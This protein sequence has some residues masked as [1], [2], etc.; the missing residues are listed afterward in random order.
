[1]PEKIKPSEFAAKIKQK[2]PSYRS[3][4]DSSLVAKIVEKYPYYKETI[5]F[6]ATEKPAAAPVAP[7][8]EVPAIDTEAAKRAQQV[9]S[10]KAYSAA[11]GVPVSDV[12]AARDAVRVTDLAM[13]AQI[14]KDVAEAPERKIIKEG[15][16]RA[17]KQTALENAVKKELQSNNIAP[18][19]GDLYWKISEDKIRKAVDEGSL[20]LTTNNAGEPVYKRNYGIIES[21]TK[22]LE[23]SE[24]ART[25]SEVFAKDDINGKIRF[26][27]EYL[28]REP[29]GVAKFFPEMMAGAVRPITE[30]VVGGMAGTAIAPGAGTAAGILGS[31]ITMT[32]TAYNRGAMD[33][34]IQMYAKDIEEIK[35]KK[36]AVTEKDKQEAM[37]RA[38]TQGVYGGLAGVAEAA[39]LTIP[40]G[41]PAA[42]KGLT[43]ALK[44]FG[45][46]SAQ[47]AKKMAAI[48]M[49]TASVKDFAASASGYNVSTSESINNILESGVEGAKT[50]VAF[51]IFHAPK[52]FSK[53]VVAYAK[54]Y[55]STIPRPELNNMSSALEG[56]GV[57]PKGSTEAMN[58]ELDKF[59]QAKSK[60]P[61]SVPEQDMGSYA[62]LVEAKDS[63]EQQKKLSDPSFH[64]QFD[65]KIKAIDERMKKMQQSREPIV[66]EVDDL[67]GDTGEPEVQTEETIKKSIEMVEPTDA[68]IEIENRRREELYA[69]SKEADSMTE[70][71]QKRTAF[72]RI[73]KRVEVNKRYDEE[74]A[75]LKRK[76]AETEVDIESKKA[77]IEKEKKQKLEN[78]DRGLTNRQDELVVS[79]EANDAQVGNAAKYGVGSTTK[80]ELTK[81]EQ[82]EVKSQFRL[83]NDGD[84]TT[85]EF[86]NWRSDFSKRV[87]NRVKE[88]INSEYNAKIAALE[89]KP[90]EVAMVSKEVTPTGAV[91][92]KAEGVKPA[93]PT[94]EVPIE[95]VSR[96]FTSTGLLVPSDLKSVKI[97]E[98]NE[99]FKNKKSIKGDSDVIE[100]PDGETRN[101][102]FAVVELD[103]ILA[104]HD[105]TSFNDTK[106]YP[107]QNGLNANPRNY[108]KDV[109]AQEKVK[110]D[111]SNLKS[112]ITIS[113]AATPETGVPIISEDGIVV[114]GNG[115]TMA[116]KLSRSVAPEKYSAY[117]NKLI[118]KAKKFGID[119]NEI[120]SM[121]SPVLVKI[122][123]S[124]KDYSIKELDAYNQKSQK[125][126]SPVDKAIKRSSIISNNKQLKDGILNI[127]SGHDTMTDLFQN[128]A[129]RGSIID[130]FEENG[131]ITA[132]ERSEYVGENKE[133][134][135]AGKDLVNDVL[136]ATIVNPEVMRATENVKSFRRNIVNAMPLLTENYKN[137]NYS[138][139]SLINDAILMQSEMVSRG[140]KLEEFWDFVSQ[141][142]MGKPHNPDVVIMNRMISEGYKKFKDFVKKYNESA[143]TSEGG[144]FAE[145]SLTREQALEL[146]SKSENKLTEN[147]RKIISNLAG[148]YSE[149][150]RG[151]QEAGAKVF[152]RSEFEQP[153]EEPRITIEGATEAE[154]LDF[155][156][157]TKRELAKPDFDAEYRRER[158]PGESK[159]SYIRR[160]YCP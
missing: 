39:A 84:L 102:E 36:G 1:M 54:N 114:S 144:L 153:T 89:A 42:G 59:Q 56:K 20:V 40:V 75:A 32:P 52:E 125:G 107:S 27:D 13:K 101:A 124:I 68:E 43:S 115:R 106:G 41:N 134:T 130:L 78:I 33:R 76:P 38:T 14:A 16:L 74:L 79:A 73:E 66:D 92:V 149:Y 123:K 93:E 128:K 155:D 145:E 154:Q 88:E 111:A 34:T 95:K 142:Q 2:Y 69:I 19:E 103:D 97:G 72:D 64:Q 47:E 51:S 67:T 96:K 157:F 71:E 158:V 108:K 138:L 62:G 150:E 55:L 135:D 83:Y 80:I 10:F 15:K 29:E 23:E 49:T 146:M 61:K 11:M 117:V 98:A 120:K 82:K 22:T 70:E 5:D 119:P 30:A 35:A 53:P 105:E 37:G 160:K 116:I 81:D 136:L 4:D 110:R 86:N 121:K 63:L 77:D 152:E 159:E 156:E 6:S 17:A 50:G 60:V 127:V 148:I 58:A 26:A 133:L 57:I 94:A 28:K 131:I 91:E 85:A 141:I 118:E 46:H 31:V 7:K 109:V 122:D 90:A 100:M 129:D 24:K 126:E 45:K 113:D 140:Y 3:I 99:E 44:N 143:K 112:S 12:G 104:S 48:S 132:Q 8:E 87:L 25:E 21:F 137:T 139:E 147:E 65:D 18:V 151:Q 9:P